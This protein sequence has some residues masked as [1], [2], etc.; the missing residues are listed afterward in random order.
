MKKKYLLSKFFY[1]EIR[2][3]LRE[4]LKN[5]ITMVMAMMMTS[6][7]RE[8]KKTINHCNKIIGT[9]NGQQQRQQNKTEIIVHAVQ[10]QH[11]YVYK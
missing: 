6:G 11:F 10:Q 1:L 4:K 7:G 9:K 5:H 8:E 2:K 3:S